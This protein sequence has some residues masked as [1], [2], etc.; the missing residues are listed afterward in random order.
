MIYFS[1]FQSKRTT[2]LMLVIS[3]QFAYWKKNI[4]DP[5]YNQGCIK[6]LGGQYLSA[7]APSYLCQGHTHLTIF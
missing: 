3:K 7:H 1:L 2:S 6:I 5:K 4:R